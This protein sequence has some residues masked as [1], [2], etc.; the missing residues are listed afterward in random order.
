MQPLSFN[1]EWDEPKAEGSAGDA[2]WG[3]LEVRLRDVVVWPGDQ[4]GGAQAVRWTWIELLET[5]ADRWPWLKAEHGW[6]RGVF[7]ET[8]NDFA[9][10]SRRAIDAALEPERSSVAQD[11][12]D[13]RWRHDLSRGLQGIAL[14]ELWVVREGNGV[15]LGSRGQT[16]RTTFA[17]VLASIEALCERIA[18]RVR[19]IGDERARAAL[20]AWRFRDKATLEQVVGIATGLSEEDLEVISG[21][22]L[23]RTF[24]MRSGQVEATELAAAARMA[25]VVAEPAALRVILRVMRDVNVRRC[26]DLDALSRDA[27][28]D[29]KIWSADRA[30][31]EG[32]ELA[33]WLRGRLDNQHA[34][35]DPA[36]LLKQWN[37]AVRNVPF[38]AP[39]VDAVACWGPRH[40]PAI[41]LNSAA[42]RHGETRTRA[43]LAHEIAHLLV[44]RR[45]ALPLSEVMGGQVPPAVERRAGAFAAELLLPRAI[46]KET[47]EADDAE[48]GVL[49][50]RLCRRYQVS[51]ELAALQ[52]LNSGCKVSRRTY[53]FLRKLAPRFRHSP[54]NAP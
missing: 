35:I 11:L 3:K 37:V 12:Y 25:S 45:D 42:R 20:A 4:S 1:L 41:L 23:E 14:P 17:T 18:E 2:T 13:F 39:E 43:T 44:D 52:V 33:Q 32:H 29:R 24:E 54:W 10:E 19:N 6:P 21:G 31:A 27:L 40:G 28:A 26:P 5:L 53:G 7:A 36:G 16:L 48:P 8:P 47:F 9:S 15:W 49:L 30:F 22:D 46:A 38:D 51:K 50:A 34:M